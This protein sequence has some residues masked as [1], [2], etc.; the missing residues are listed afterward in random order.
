[1]A[2]EINV[3]RTQ[4]MIQTALAAQT[5]AYKTEFAD[6]ER[7][8]LADFDDRLRRATAVKAPPSSP[9]SSTR[10]T[11]K[12]TTLDMDSSLVY[13]GLGG[14][15]TS[16]ISQAVVNRHTSAVPPSTSAQED[17]YKI[18][19]M[20]QTKVERS[21]LEREENQVTDSGLVASLKFFDDYNHRWR[22]SLREFLG[23]TWLQTLERVQGSPF[24]TSLMVRRICVLESVFNLP[25]SF[26]IRIEAAFLCHKV[27]LVK[28]KVSLDAMQS[29][30]ARFAA[31]LDDWV[32][33]F[34][35]PN[36]RSLN[37]R[38]VGSFYKG[39]EPEPLR[40]LVSHFPVDH[41]C[42]VFDQFKLQ[43]T[44]SVVEMVNLKTE[45]SFR[46]RQFRSRQQQ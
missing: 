1:M 40:M 20:D 44:A 21:L 17:F 39:I 34:P 31:T 10:S 13:N 15:S 37:E 24:R 2:N 16:A 9:D 32:P 5:E 18:F 25:E 6:R 29:F 22:N 46:D 45:K 43:C 38:L 8:L 35:D 23:Q 14:T 4:Q 11:V 3:E 19:S 12:R 7:I 42:D 28:G 26:N 30:A 33:R 41:V 36:D 27:E